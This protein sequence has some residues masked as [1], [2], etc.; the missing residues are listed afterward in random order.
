MIT[1]HIHNWNYYIHNL[2][3]C[4]LFT[5]HLNCK[6]EIFSQS[7]KFLWKNFWDNIMDVWVWRATNSWLRK[8]STCWISPIHDILFTSI[9]CSYYVRRNKNDTI[10]E[11]VRMC[12]MRVHECLALIYNNNIKFV[13]NIFQFSGFWSFFWIVICA[14]VKDMQDIIIVF[15]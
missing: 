8:C 7:W 14:H 6:C 1:I 5:Q 15:W 10:K 9:I 3:V 12:N 2:T 11:I 13:K 4:I